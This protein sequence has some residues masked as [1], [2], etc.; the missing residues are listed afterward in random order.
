M[1][2]QSGALIRKGRPEGSPQ[3]SQSSEFRVRRRLDHDFGETLEP[4]PRNYNH[5]T[6][7]LEHADHVSK[8]CRMPKLVNDTL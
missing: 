1:P 2:S 7:K 5:D 6:A 3:A 4:S 8:R